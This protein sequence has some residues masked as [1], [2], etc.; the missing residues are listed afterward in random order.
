MSIPLI[1]RT[2]TIDEWR[3]QTNLEATALNNLET[4]NYVKSN[5]SLSL[6]AN[7]SLII[8]ANGTA[9][10]V[11]NSA[12]FQSNVTIAGDIALGTQGSATGN[13]TTGGIVIVR[14]PGNALQVANNA[15]VNTDLQV[16]RTIYTGN[17]SA[18]GNVN[19]GGNSTVSGILRLPGSGDVLYVNTGVAVV[20]TL[21]AIDV[22]T[23]NADID[24]VT[25]GQEN[26]T[27]ST[28]SIGTIING[29]VVTLTS[30]QANIANSVLAK[31]TINSANVDLVNIS[32]A[33]VTSL[34]NVQNAIVRVRGTSASDDALTISLGKTTVQDVVIQGNLTVSGTYTQTG[35]SN[36]EID[37]ITLNA[38]TNV[39]KDAFIVNRRISGNNAVIQWNEVDKNWKVSRGNTYSALNDV[40]D[41]SYVLSV[42]TSNS[43]TNVASAS[44]AKAA[45]D[46]AVVAGGYANS[47][48]RSQ[49]TSGVY[50]NTAYLHANASYVSQNTT[51][52]YANT[53][54]LHANASYVSQNT[55]GVYANTAYLHANASYVSQNTTGVYANTSYTH[56]NASFAF[57]N[58][59]FASAGGTISG[60]VVINGNL[61]VN[62]TQT[63]VNSTVTL[64]ADPILT[65]NADWP[66][67]SVPIE[68]AGIEV[69]RGSSANTV[70][71]WNETTDKWEFTNDGT[72]YGD[73]ASVSQVTASGS[74]ANSAYTQANT[75]TTNAATA[76]QRAVTS[77]SYAN[78]AY[79]QANTATTNA[80]TADQ[81]AVTS[82]SFA[83]S[84][85]ARAN[86]AVSDAA[87]ANSNAN[88]R[89]SKSGDT[90]SGALQVNSTIGATGTITAPL[91]SGTATAARY[92][93]LAEKYTTDLEY[94]IGTVVV[95]NPEPDSEA[96]KSTSIS[97][98]VLGVISEKP[99]Y[100]M[101]SESTGQA[102]ALRGRVPV[103]VVGPVK[104]GQT[105]VSGP[106]G[107]ASV[108]EVNRFAIALESKDAH[109]EGNIEVVIL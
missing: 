10:Q 74:Y 79:G 57:A 60:A 91:F 23:T 30:N 64:F 62:G 55:T 11:S 56:A 66:M 36:I 9:L 52:V 89:V 46:T 8:T 25:I 85:F 83:N 12:L 102:I 69:Q 43:T 18:N 109:E 94:S 68:N 14:G 13:L 31:T 37:T 33:N 98:L 19:V 84:A 15:T 54:Y 67:A 26:V 76:N 4:G 42:V 58:T 41:S 40:L 53:S 106:D 93:D 92:A 34:L 27:L 95:V 104:K 86:T 38:N 108:G 75:A 16:T 73:I 99:A 44:A 78:S 24:L 100:L 2:N 101:N 21:S 6:T 29:N 87:S 48:F 32:T 80:A 71:R 72:N 82:G 28:I 65:L 3:V 81:R 50:A 103:R 39:N 49:N 7:S 63:Y 47:A 51:G 5:G 35:N 45:F 20:K 70:L 97:Q 17:V 59:R 22:N 107:I 105:L 77:G 61:T 88:G 96:T 1:S 90:M